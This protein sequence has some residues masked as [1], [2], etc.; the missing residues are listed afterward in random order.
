MIRP[1]AAQPSVESAGGTEDLPRW[2][3]EGCALAATSTTWPLCGT[4]SDWY[5]CRFEKQSHH[6]TISHPMS[7]SLPLVLSV[8]STNFGHQNWRWPP[9][10]SV[11]PSKTSPCVRSKRPV[12]AGTTRTCWNTCARG[13]GTHGDV[14]NVHTGTFWVDTRD[15]SACYTTHH[16][17]HTPQHKTQHTTTQHQQHNTKQHDTPQH[18]STTQP[19][20]HTETETEKD[21]ERQR[22]REETEREEKTEEER[23]DKRREKRQREK[24]RQKRRDKTREERTDKMRREDVRRETRQEKREETGWEEK[25]KEERQDKRREKRGKRRWKRRERRWKRR[26]RD[27]EK[28]KRERDEKRWKKRFFKKNIQNS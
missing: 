23:Q 15:F 14:L 3:A 9:C 12:H 6:T 25:M 22:K 19:Q 2:T 4:S 28:M 21:R 10:P 20:Y 16:T 26:S 5:W 13:A 1:W 8:R 11:C 17:A 18:T 7:T 27:Q 24:K